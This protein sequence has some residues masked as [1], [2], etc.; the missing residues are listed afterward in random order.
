MWLVNHMKEHSDDNGVFSPEE[1][2]FFCVCVLSCSVRVLDRRSVFACNWLPTDWAEKP[3]GEFTQVRRYDTVTCLLAPRFPSNEKWNPLKTEFYWPPWFSFK[4]ELVFVADQ[5]LIKLKNSAGQTNCVKLD[6]CG[7]E[8]HNEHRHR[9]VRVR[10]SHTAG[11]A[12]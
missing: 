7:L 4:C 12:M 9:S 2:P 1:Q 10:S 6:V 8:L 5:V 11:P 3:V